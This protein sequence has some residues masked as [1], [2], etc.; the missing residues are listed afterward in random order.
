MVGQDV[1]YGKNT[2]AEAGYDDQEHKLG[3]T[4]FEDE[5]G[6][7]DGERLLAS[8]LHLLCLEFCVVFSAP[9]LACHYPA[10]QSAD[11]LRSV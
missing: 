3:L 11:I 8:V 2:A 5:H 10:L 1:K 6:E 7:D 9:G 4:L